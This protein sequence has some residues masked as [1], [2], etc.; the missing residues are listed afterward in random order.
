[1]QLLRREE[2][3]PFTKVEPHLVTEDPQGPRPGA[4]RTIFPVLEDE[5]EE[6][7]IRLHGE[8]RTTRARGPEGA[9]CKRKVDLRIHEGVCLVDVDEEVDLRRRRLGA[10][11]GTVR[12]TD[13]AR[14]ERVHSV[15]VIAFTSALNARIAIRRRTRAD[16]PRTSR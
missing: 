3:K 1:V 12:K 15:L 7:E 14:R 16:R 2:R 11:G 13:T 4:I 10:S 9:V 5:P 6:I 8:P